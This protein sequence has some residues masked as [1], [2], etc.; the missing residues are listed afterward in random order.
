MFAAENCETLPNDPTVLANLWYVSTRASYFFGVYLPCCLNPPGFVR[1]NRISIIGKER[2][3]GG[4]RRDNS[5]RTLC[6]CSFS[7]SPGA[8]IFLRCHWANCAFEK[9]TPVSSPLPSFAK[10]LSLPS[11]GSQAESGWE[12]GSGNRRDFPEIPSLP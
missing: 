3:G 11:F 12:S 9:A 1:L 6:H 2:A 10:P 8:S 5:A 4:R 7:P